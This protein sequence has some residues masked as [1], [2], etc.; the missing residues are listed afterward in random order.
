MS[1]PVSP[2]IAARLLAADLDKRNA[3]KARIAEDLAHRERV[4]RAEFDLRLALYG[5]AVQMHMDP[6]TAEAVQFVRDTPHPSDAGE[7]PFVSNCYQQGDLPIFHRAKNVNAWRIKERV[8]TTGWS[9]NK[10]DY[11]CI[12]EKF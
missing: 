3:L 12:R 7:R 11:G 4:I 1:R 5:I 10:P 6:L 8:T 2:I 9:V